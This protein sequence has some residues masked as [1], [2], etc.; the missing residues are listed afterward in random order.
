MLLDYHSRK[1]LHVFIKIIYSQLGKIFLKNLL[2]YSLD[3]Q[4]K[5]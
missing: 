2:F 3:K 4:G 1:L 5:G